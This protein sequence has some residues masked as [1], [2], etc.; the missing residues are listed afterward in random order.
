MTSTIII[1]VPPELKARLVKLAN[2]SEH[3]KLSPYLIS[4]LEEII[5]ES[6]GNDEDELQIAMELLGFSLIPDHFSIICDQCKKSHIR[7]FSN[8]HD[9]LCGACLIHKAIKEGGCIHDDA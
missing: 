6:E 2:K 7:I 1:K 9:Y 5:N 4:K 8:D 3:N